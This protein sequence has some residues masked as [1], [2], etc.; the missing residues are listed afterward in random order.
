MKRFIFL[1]SL[2][3]IAV[4]A[5][6][7][8]APVAEVKVPYGVPDILKLSRAQVNEGVILSY[9]QNSGTVYNLEANDI[10]YLRG[11]GVSDAVVTAM[12]NQRRGTSQYA[13]QPTPAHQT[14]QPAHPSFAPSLPHSIGKASHYY[15]P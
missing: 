15:A 10:V 3:L 12:L 13:S 7:D 6:A 14:A 1:S 5:A 8:P 11:Q 4:R 2:L 9:I